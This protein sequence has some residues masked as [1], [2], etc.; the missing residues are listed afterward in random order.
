MLGDFEDR[1]DDWDWYGCEGNS[2]R[3]AVV[4]MKFLLLRLRVS[5]ITYKWHVE[6]VAG[7]DEAL[8][9]FNDRLETV[10]PVF[11]ERFCAG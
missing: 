9:L 8:L 3:T 7:S 5:T 6:F 2:T 10:Q 11:E 1:A 4:R